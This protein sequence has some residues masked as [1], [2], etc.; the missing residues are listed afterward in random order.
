MSSDPASNREGIAIDD[1]HIY[2]NTN[3]I[4]DGA[5]M[6]GPVTR[7]VSGN[8]WIDFTSSGK[9]IASLQPNNQNLG[10]TDVQAYIDTGLVR[11]TSSQYYLSRNITIKPANSVPD[12]VKVRFY[13]L[14]KESDS[15]ITATGCTSCAK[16]T[17]AYELGVSKYS[18]PDK[19]FE[20]GSIADDQQGFW[21][22]VNSDNVVKVPF[23]KGYYAEFKVKDFSEFWL[24]NGSIDK[25]SPL[26]VKLMEFT[27]QKQN[28]DVLLKWNVGSEAEVAQYEIE[29]ARGN[30]ELQAGQFMK[31]G[32][33]SSLGNT[34]SSRTY[35]FTDTESDKF[36]PRYYRLKIINIDGSF[37]Y[38]LIRSVVFND[39]VL[40]QIYPN[41]SNGL[42][43][44]VYQLN[45]N[46]QIT[47]RVIDAKGSVIREYHKTTNGFLQKLNIDLFGKASGVY[48]LQI[49]ARGK[50][51]TFKLYKNE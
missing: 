39:A 50:Q 35:T 20:N 38:S 44:L 4:Y 9:L 47:A 28:I 42:F 22:F 18:D 36:G 1:I 7:T 37:T 10:I 33:V 49:D 32:E 26:S 51:Q 25:I 48:L 5:A 14:D 34:T 30:T 19:S 12:S 31:I 13:F 46:N 16:P 40:W 23:D 27:A 43:S 11:H 3:G 29:V 21:S 17:T 45:N 41:P 2:D 8:S 15:L 6:S 24:N